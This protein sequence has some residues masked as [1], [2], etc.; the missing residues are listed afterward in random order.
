M[1]TMSTLKQKSTWC[2]R[3]AIAC[4]GCTLLL[5]VIH[6]PS[7]AGRSA[8]ADPGHDYTT[9]VQPLI[10]KY[11]LDCHSTK[12][13]KGSL[14]LE[15]FITVDDVRRDIKPWQALIEMLETAEMPPKNRPQPSVEQ[16][17]QLIT[18]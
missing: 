8:P 4:L 14:D 5:L 11:C 16:R 2:R 17:K 1:Y 12:I 18:W 10:K 3:A 6:R 7:R 15:R 13:K 9:T